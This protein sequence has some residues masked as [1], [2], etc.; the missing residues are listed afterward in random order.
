MNNS[1]ALVVIIGIIVFF[2][3]L[4]FK[5]FDVQIIKSDELKYYAERQQT[6]LEKVEPERGLIYDRDDV[7]LAYNKNDVS[8]FLDLRMADKAD[9]QKIAEKFSSVFGKS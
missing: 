2:F 7:L 8:F 6:K 3:A 5:L 9:R 1:S 4:L